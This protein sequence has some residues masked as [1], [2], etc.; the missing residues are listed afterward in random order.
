[1]KHAKT[2]SDDGFVLR[3]RRFRSVRFRRFGASD[4]EAGRERARD[5]TAEASSVI[6]NPCKLY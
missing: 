5:M 1:M 6:K 3:V 2:L 4:A